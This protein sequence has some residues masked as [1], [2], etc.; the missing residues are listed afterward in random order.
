MSTPHKSK[1]QNSHD[2]RRHE[3]WN[4]NPRT[5]PAPSSR[6]G[7]RSRWWHQPRW[8][9]VPGAHYWPYV[10]PECRMC[11]RPSESEPRVGPSLA[12]QWSLI[13]RTV[14]TKMAEM[15]IAGE[16]LDESLPCTR[17][18]TT[19]VLGASCP[20]V[21]VRCKTKVDT[22][23]NCSPITA[24]LF[25]NCQVPTVQGRNLMT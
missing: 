16:W 4:P 12:R 1:E 8:L 14:C 25:T 6:E 17:E 5:K 3:R 13:D 10:N 19:T 18:R 24:I 21:R 15:R 20:N 7:I 11:S 9:A 22:R 23:K 2:Y